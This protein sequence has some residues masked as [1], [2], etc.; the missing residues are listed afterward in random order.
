M[1][2]AVAHA[3]ELCGSVVEVTTSGGEELRI[4]DVTTSLPT[5]RIRASGYNEQ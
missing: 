3:L 2:V 4:T 1:S 5:T